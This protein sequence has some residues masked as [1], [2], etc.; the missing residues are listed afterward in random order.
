MGDQKENNLSS[1]IDELEKRVKALE[2]EKGVPSKKDESNISTPAL[3]QE[4]AAPPDDDVTE[5][6]KGF[7]LNEQWLN[8]IGIT[9]LLIGVAFL[10]K[11]SVDQGWLIP[12]IRSAIGL[13]IGVTLFFGGLQMN[14]DQS[15]LKQILMGGGIAAFY[16][17]GFATFQLYSF[18]PSTVVW[19]FMII[20]TLLALS[21]SLQQDE[22]VLSVV[23]TLGAFGT[24]FMLHTGGGS[25]VL[26]MI[27][28]MLVLAGVIVIYMQ[29]GWKSL[30]WTYSLGSAAVIV[31]GIATADTSLESWMLQA[32]AV[33]WL[34]GSWLLPVFRNVFW[35]SD[36]KGWGDPGKEQ[37]RSQKK[38]R[39]N[40]SV[41]FMVVFAPL[42]MLAVTIGIWELSM[43][44]AGYVAMG[45]SALAALLYRPLTNN[46]CTGLAS[47]HMLLGLGMLTIGFMLLLEQS[48]LFVT[49]TVEAVCL[50]YIAHQTGDGKL[51]IAGH[52][53]FGIVVLWVVEAFAYRPGTDPLLW[54]V[55]PF[56]QLGVIAV[57]ALVI[58]R[59]L[60]QTKL[61]KGYRIV[62]HL[63][64]LIWM[65]QQLSLIENGQPWITVAWG[66]YAT[67]LLILGF[68]QFG[69]LMRLTGMATILLVVAKLFIVDLSQLQAIWRIFLFIGFGAV[70]LL[71]G[72]YGQSHF[73]DKKDGGELSNK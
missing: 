44:H 59:W 17:T 1:R 22:A 57:G 34:L 18:L 72:Y 13:G 62:S 12:P 39:P 56:T 26:L 54:N 29:K 48:I 32:G 7:E 4:E 15:P 35:V 9:L 40:P 16:I 55:R 67:I 69:R 11:Y 41:Q 33:V 42:L 49:L 53:L 63:V 14:T 52:I 66:A 60:S 31:V 51:N 65:Y 61:K 43:V 71:L 20:V 70:F 24:P 6:S 45:L 3:R 73:M 21:L 30:L 38:I 5:E 50:R 68:I 8:R 2:E 27:Y 10:F 28:T 46:Q 64:F 23:G 47:T 58:P 37:K 19:S 36:S 25:V